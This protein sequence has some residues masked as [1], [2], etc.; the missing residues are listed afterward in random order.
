[1]K[2]TATKPKDLPLKDTPPNT[3]IFITKKG[4][5]PKVIKSGLLTKCAD[6]AQ[7]EKDRDK[8]KKK[9]KKCVDDNAR[10]ATDQEIETITLLKSTQEELNACKTQANGDKAEI[11][12]CEEQ[13]IETLKNVGK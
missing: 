1:M 13:A 6:S 7:R 5:Q 11:R 9:M 10:D 3:D 4:E 12:K 2:P 8:G